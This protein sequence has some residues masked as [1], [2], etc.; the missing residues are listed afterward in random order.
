MGERE[1]QSEKQERAH[2]HQRDAGEELRHGVSG[3]GG[4]GRSSFQRWQHPLAALVRRGGV[5]RERQL[6][7]RLHRGEVSSEQRACISLNLG[8]LRRGDGRDAVCVCAVGEADGSRR[9]CGTT[10]VLVVVW[11]E[12]ELTSAGSFTAVGSLAAVRVV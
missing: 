2:Q 6:R 12:V 5:A 4:G 3:G 8:S 10:R 1:S 9:S 11:W 7:A